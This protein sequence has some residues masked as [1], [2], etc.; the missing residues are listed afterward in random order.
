MT[1]GPHLSASAGEGGRR[2]R[3]TGGGAGPTGPEGLL[4]RARRAGA[5]AAGLVR[6]D[7]LKVKKEKGREGKKGLGICRKG[8]KQWNSNLS[9]NPSNQKI[10]HQHEC[11]K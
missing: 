6:A 2:G 5:V 3:A 8:F 9:L 10:M 4:G 11:H 1:G 7:G